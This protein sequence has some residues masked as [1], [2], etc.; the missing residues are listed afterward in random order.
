MSAG[1]V[2]WYPDDRRIVSNKEWRPTSEVVG[3]A[4]RNKVGVVWRYERHAS[5][6]DKYQAHQSNRPG[7][8]SIRLWQLK[9]L[10]AVSARSTLHCCNSLII[11]HD[12]GRQHITQ[13]Y[14]LG[15]AAVHVC[16]SFLLNI[17][18]KVARMVQLRRLQPYRTRPPFKDREK[19]EDKGR[20]KIEM[21]ARCAQ[22]PGH[23]TYRKLISLPLRTDRPWVNA[24]IGVPSWEDPGESELLTS[25]FPF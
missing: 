2:E 7:F 20:P 1:L 8:A 10:I 18:V 25:T 13:P 16:V 21:E 19:G 11:G 6:A 15:S 14:V 22:A 17:R 24:V 3:W 9:I 23:C 4:I 5:G 12:R